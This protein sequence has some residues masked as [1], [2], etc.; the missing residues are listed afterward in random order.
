VRALERHIGR[1]VL[2]MVLAN[3]RID[4][5]FKPPS[6]VDMVLMESDVPGSSARIV[7]TD[8]AADEEPWRHDSHKLA[9]AVM[10]LV[11]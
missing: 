5:G 8:L 2:D 7:H 4:R 10:R 11:R 3:D 9:E 1:D 6:G